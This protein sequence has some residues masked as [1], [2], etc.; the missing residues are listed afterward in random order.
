MAPIQATELCAIVNGRVVLPGRV[1]EDRALLVGGGRIA[2]LQ[3]VDQLPAGWVM[4][5]AHGGWVTPG[6]IDIHIHGAVGHTF[7]EGTPAAFDAITRACADAGVTSLLATTTTAP[8]EQLVQALVMLKAWGQTPQDDAQSPCAQIL[9]AHVEGPYFAPS[10]AGAQDPKHLRVP[11][12]GAYEQL[13]AY[14]DLIRIFTFAPELPGAAQLADRLVALGVVPAAGH[15]AAREEDVR[16]LLARGLRHM[17][18]LWSG[19]STTIREGAWR[20]PGLLEVSLAYDGLTAEMIADGKHLPPTLMRLACKCVGPERLCIISD[21]TSGAGLP[22]GARFCMGEMEYEVRDGVGMMLDGSA[23]A[24]STT[25]LN[26]MVRVVIEQVGLPVVD[27]VRM[28]SQTPARVIGVDSHKG[29]L[30]PGKDADIV[31]FGDDWHPRR[32][33][34]KGRW[35]AEAATDEEMRDV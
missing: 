11:A 23:F 5:D 26:Q 24:G 33:M 32:V 10:Q 25:L 4:V 21:A 3:P 17:I 15:S 31:I 29:S 34:I 30:M 28:A 19:Q 1:V 6:L 35:L 18:H 22:D 12:D 8:I 9:G 2:G 7:N 16:P 14:A 27:A 20:K 13:L